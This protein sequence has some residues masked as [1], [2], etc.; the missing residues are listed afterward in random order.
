M[1]AE[2]N[3]GRLASVF[4]SLEVVADEKNR[5]GLLQKKKKKRGFKEYSSSTELNCMD[6]FG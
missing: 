4:A 6:H 5:V 3:W 1:R 2:V